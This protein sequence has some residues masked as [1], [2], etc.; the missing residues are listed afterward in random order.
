MAE[1]KKNISSTPIY[2]KLQYRLTKGR[3]VKRIY[4]ASYDEE[5][6][7]HVI[8]IM[9]HIEKSLEANETYSLL[10]IRKDIDRQ[11][12]NFDWNGITPTLLLSTIK[13]WEY[14]CSPEDFIVRK[15]AD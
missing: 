13:M 1:I 15:K 4:N 11:N 5:V 2:Q 3:K 10:N 8:I 14:D 7:E 9:R 6:Q 12:E